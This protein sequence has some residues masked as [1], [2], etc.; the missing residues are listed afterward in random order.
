M[1]KTAFNALTRL[2][3]RPAVLKRLGNPDI[4]SLI[5]ITPSNYFR[6]LRGPEYTT[7]KGVEFIIPKDTMV[8]HVAQKLVFNKVP[9]AGN[10]KISFGVLETTSLP[11]NTNA[12]AI[13]TAV[14]LLSGLNNVVVTG[15][16]TNGFVFT[17]VGSSAPVT[18][19]DITNSTLANGADTSLTDTWTRQNT[20]WDKLILKGDR[21]VDGSSQW[22][23]DEIVHMHDVGAE[24]MGY[25]CRCD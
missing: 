22:S 14:R 6:F 23:V 20:P 19:G 9:D 4:Y 10:F 24:L 17:F 16:F 12:A 1:L 11:F 15:D 5:R 18:L 13:Q 25:R 3:S 2:H 21:I 8:G 7:V